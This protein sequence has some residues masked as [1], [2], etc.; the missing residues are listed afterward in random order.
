VDS[1]YPSGPFFIHAE[2]SVCDR[3]RIL[4]E[5]AEEGARDSRVVAFAREAA[6]G[7][8]GAQ[9]AA[10]VLA[11]V[12]A[13]PYVDEPPGEEWFQPAAY[14]LAHGGDCDDLVV[15]FVAAMRVLSVPAT[16]YWIT[17]TGQRLNHVTAQV[18][19]SGRWLWAETTIPGARLG[20][21]P[22]EAARRLGTGDRTGVMG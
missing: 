8:S 2:T 1:R 19:L 14:T 11:R 20:E 5:L 13:L 3:V 12:Q 18:Y 7:S 22:Y 16:V 6:S 4:T 10:N 15:L 17:Q 9:A 21:S